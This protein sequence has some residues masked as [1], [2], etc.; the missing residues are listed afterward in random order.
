MVLRCFRK[1]I[2]LAGFSAE[3]QAPMVVVRGTGCKEPKEQ[4]RALSFMTLSQMA[5]VPISSEPRARRSSSMSKESVMSDLFDRWE[6]V[7]HQGQYNL[8][9][10]CVGKDYVRHDEK[11]DRTVTR[12]AYAAEIVA[13]REERPKTRF[14]VYDHSFEGD[15]AWFRFTLKWTDT[16]NVHSSRHATL[17][18]RGRQARGDLAYVPTTRLGMDRRRCARALDEPAANQVSD[19]VEKPIHA[20]TLVKA[21]PMGRPNVGRIRF[22]APF[23]PIT[24]ALSD[25]AGTS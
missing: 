2:V 25:I 11:G 19:M 12:E 14:V 5:V 3:A 21:L 24:C 22:V 9:T 13:T 4:S 7:W 15:R 23:P 17:P 10:S 1:E 18:D 8:I 16:K 20:K 6:R